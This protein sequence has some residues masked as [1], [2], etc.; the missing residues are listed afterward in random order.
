[1]SLPTFLSDLSPSHL[2]PLVSTSLLFQYEGVWGP[3]SLLPE[4]QKSKS[5]SPI[6]P[7]THRSQSQVGRAL[8]SSTCSPADKVLVLDFFILPR[9]DKSGPQ[10]PPPLETQKFSPLS[11]SI[12]L[13]TIKIKK[14]KKKRPQ[15]AQRHTQR[16]D[17]RLT[18]EAEIGMVAKFK[19]FKELTASTRNLEEARKNSALE[20]SEGAWAC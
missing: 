15:K 8:R 12:I 19:E 14:N 10:H 20:P 18:M 4:T 17:G 6:F 16:E 2:W 11:S 1:M 13:S 7:Q 9:T 3:H 5:P